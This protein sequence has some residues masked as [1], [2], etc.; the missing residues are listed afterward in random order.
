MA[1]HTGIVQMDKF[2]VGE[3]AELRHRLGRAEGEAMVLRD[4]LER[5]RERADGERAGRIRAQAEREAARREL[6]GWTS[7]GPFARAL[8][9]L[10][11]RQRQR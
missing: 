9:A 11:F 8:R 6:M 4:A 7:G 3:L 10:L 1:P 2:Q 5:E